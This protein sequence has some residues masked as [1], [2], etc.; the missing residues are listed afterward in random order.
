MDVP[1]EG[2]PMRVSLIL[3]TSLSMFCTTSGNAATC[4]VPRQEL[5][6]QQ[7]IGLNEQ[8]VQAFRDSDAGW[9][10]R[11]VAD[12]FYVVA[13]SGKVVER[14]TFL[15]LAAGPN[16]VRSMQLEKVEVRVSGELAQVTAETPFER[17]DGSTGRNRYIDT[18]QWRDC[19][20]QT[21]SAQI[22][23]VLQAVALDARCTEGA[24]C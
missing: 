13:S 2:V 21:V 24:A 9:Y 20:W 7:I 12:D 15:E 11:H 16:G 6:E 23:P 3:L 10:R 1:A 8:Y 4:P 14:E 18:W 5:A 19:R 22:T 17:D